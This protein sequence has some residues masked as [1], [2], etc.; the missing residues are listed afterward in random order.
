MEMKAPAKKADKFLM[1]LKHFMPLLSYYLP[2]EE[3]N[4]NEDLK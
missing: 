3:L 2:S 4:G 1:E